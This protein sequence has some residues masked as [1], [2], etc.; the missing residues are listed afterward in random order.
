MKYLLL[1]SLALA[2]FTQA[3]TYVLTFGGTIDASLIYDWTS[4]VFENAHGSRYSYSVQIDTAQLDQY[5]DTDSLGLYT[6]NN[7]TWTVNGYSF[8]APATSCANIFLPNTQQDALQLEGFSFTEAWSAHGLTFDGSV[9]TGWQ[10]ALGGGSPDVFTTDT[11]MEL[12]DASASDFAFSVV[13]FFT[14][15]S[16]VSRILFANVDAIAYAPIPEPSTYTEIAGALALGLV[17]VRRRRK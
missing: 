13:R 3:E 4:P 7:P 14:Q 9:Q 15:D 12:N 8:T 17:A 2:N 16:G 11:L 6:G 5:P 10:F 1:S